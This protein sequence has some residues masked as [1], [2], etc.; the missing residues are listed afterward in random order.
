MHY[1]AFSIQH[2]KKGTSR[3][4]V[5]AIVHAFSGCGRCEEKGCPCCEGG[6]CQPECQCHKG[7]SCGTC[8]FKTGGKTFRWILAEMKG[9][10]VFAIITRNEMMQLDVYTVEEFEFKALRLL[11]DK[12]REFSET[13]HLTMTH[14]QRDRLTEET[15]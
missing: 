8:N 12:L 1:T 11:N 6:L 7:K 9:G 14:M 13:E 2:L 3:K 10:V 15:G 4:A 5:A